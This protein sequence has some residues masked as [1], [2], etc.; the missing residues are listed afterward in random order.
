MIG[1]QVNEA[2]RAVVGEFFELFKTPWEFCR[3]GRHYEVLLCSDDDPPAAD[4]RLVLSY[5]TGD[6]PDDLSNRAPLIATHSPVILSCVLGR[7]PIYAGCRTF[8]P[9][10][11]SWLTDE[12]TRRP[13]ARESGS[14][15]R[16]IVHVG[17]HLFGE[18]RHLLTHGQ[19]AQCAALP[20]LE[21]HIA[22]LREIILS[23]SI[24]LVEIPPLPDGHSLIACLTH[25]VD[26]VGIRN[27]RW[28][29]T[30]L[31]FLYRATLGSIFKLCRGRM[32][33][34]Q[35]AANWA[36]VCS[37]P[38]VHL[39]LARDPWYQ[40]D[41][42]VQIEEGRPSTFFVIPK[43]GEP[44]QD[45]TGRTRPRRA[46]Q[47]DA[48]DLVDHLMRL[49]EAECEIGLHGID[50]WRD[51]AKGREESALIG[52]LI[53]ASELGVR[54][55]WLYFD[56]QSPSRLEEA[57]FTY[58]STVGYNQTIGYRAGTTQVY[59]P[60][61]TRHLLELPLH[62]MDTALFYPSYL[63]LSPSQAETAAASLIRDVARFGGVF[64]VNWHDRSLAPER[65]WGGTYLALMAD[66]T[67]RR[68]WFATAS[69]T[70]AWFRKRR[71][72]SISE[73]SWNDDGTVRI[74]ASAGHSDA[75]PGLRL[76]LHR[77][78]DGGAGRILSAIPSGGYRDIPLRADLDLCL[79]A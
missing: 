72:A 45:A 51:T 28:D 18:V 22:L 11:G 59:Q 6:G 21:L 23:C 77:G 19:P 39:G 24:P 48:A 16:R 63:D 35:V 73:V 10:E 65:L 27:H 50:A 7:I 20:A 41:H 13:V 26:H 36:A 55:H 68:A 17:Y 71:A 58:D 79:P 4:A 40:F 62:V 57:G 60:P 15:G 52:G 2:D 33:V 5:G 31:G 61:G 70:V 9:V 32:T 47:Y 42:Y 69:Q 67:R 30:L 1:V 49:R 53:G 74:R 38:W 56:E 34:R 44:G 78:R 3:P 46:A 14:D 8:D 43:K 64:T 66:L 54:M 29:H 37:L 12:Q 75:L 25:D 76:R